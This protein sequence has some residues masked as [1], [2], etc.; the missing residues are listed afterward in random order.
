MTA[1]PTNALQREEEI[2]KPLPDGW[3]RV[4]SR[5][6][7]GEFVYENI[8]SEERQAWFPDSPA[9]KARKASLFHLTCCS[10]FPRDGER[11]SR[12][13]TP[14]SSSTKISTPWTAKPGDQTRRLRVLDLS[15]VF[16][17]LVNL[18]NF[19]KRK[20]ALSIILICD[21]CC[22]LQGRGSARQEVC[23][24]SSRSY[25]SEL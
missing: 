7:P 13:L 20:L 8:Y 21:S 12:E 2:T 22:S 16:L 19:I 23:L 9:E 10:L 1:T 3:R 4:E 6:R 25:S 11:S 15:D 14:A 17:F 24:Q 18:S 5:S